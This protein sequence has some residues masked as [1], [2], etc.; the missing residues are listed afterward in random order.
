MRKRDWFWVIAAVI[1][2]WVIDQATKFWAVESLGALVFHGPVGLVLHRN[3]GAILGAFAELPPIL[4]VVSLSTGGAFLIFI[5]AA[6]QYLLP[7]RLMKLRIGISLLLG[8]ILGNVTDRII[9][10]SVVDFLLFGHSNWTTPA[11]NFADAIQWVGYGLVVYT[12]IREGQNLWPDANARKKV[13]I[14]PRFQLKYCLILVAIGLAFSI[15]AGVFSYTYLRVTIEDVVVGSPQIIE[16]RF[17]RPF[18]Q[19]F[20]VIA[21]GFMVTLFVI[22]RILSHRTAGPLY[23]FEKFLEDL[24]AGKDRSFRVRAGDEFTHLEELAK[25][26]RTKLNEDYKRKDVS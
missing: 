26:L 19:V 15:I 3:P 9:W 4:R 8:G 16:Q 14:N 22:G 5:A 17:L 7:G 12:L 20:I 1:L 10:G 13:W 24:L 11:F 2:S 25:K 23:A 21:V 18:L 6:I